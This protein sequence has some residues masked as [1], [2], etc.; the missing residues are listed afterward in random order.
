MLEINEVLYRKQ[1]DTDQIVIN[2]AQALKVELSEEVIQVFHRL[3]S[4]ANAGIIVKFTSRR[5]REEVFN[6]RNHLMKITH[7]FKTNMCS[8]M[9]V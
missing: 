2:I 9:R 8:L 4:A 6:E 3:T 5:K 1:E 7:R